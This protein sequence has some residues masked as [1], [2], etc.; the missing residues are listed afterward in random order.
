MSISW[1][2]AVG[3]NNKNETQEFTADPTINSKIKAVVSGLPR[4]ISNL[5]LEF[6][7]DD[8]KDLVANFLDSC[9]KQEN[10]SINTKRAYLIALAYLAR[11][12]K[13]PLELI[14]SSDLK[15]Y[16]DSM[17]RSQTEDPDQSWISTQRTM[18]LPLLKFFKWLAY[19]DLTPQERKQLPRDKYP[20]VL[21]GLVLH[22]K[23]GSKSPIKA[24]DIWGDED[25]GIFLKY[26]TDNP[27]LRFYHALAYETSARPGELLQLKIGDIKIDSDSATG[28]LFAA[29]DIGRY[30]KKRQSRIVGITDFSIQYYQPY[31]LSSHPN[32][33][34]KDA[35]L[36][37]SQEH[38]AFSR[39]LP[40]SGDALRLDYKTFRDKTIPRLLKRPDVPKQDKE[41]LQLLSDKKKWSP[42]TMRHS[43][44][45]KL[46][47]NPNINDYVLRQH[48]GWAK[49]SNM[50]EIYTHELSG[51]SFEDVMLAYGI[52]LKDKKNKEQAELIQKE[53]IGPHCPFCK[54]INVP[55]A[56]FCSSCN[57][58]LSIISYDKIAKEAEQQKRELQEIRTQQ[59]GQAETMRD[60]MRYIQRKIVE[61]A[62]E[63]ARKKGQEW[64][65]DMVTTWEEELYGPYS[66][67]NPPIRRLEELEEEK[68]RQQ[69]P[70]ER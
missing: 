34:S 54:M 35:Y 51:D 42:Y 2:N 22:T 18:A 26:C 7:T 33:G 9:I 48:A 41:H 17:Q 65:G 46:A 59:E 15:T 19:A 45:T 70:S 64:N 24:S 11:E 56:Q 43:S 5:F 38:S 57:K 10:I 12:V 1:E 40:I 47:R 44:I 58:P 6:P 68:R 13:K 14:T 3:I 37:L 60:M 30:G 36:F 32:S 50:V 52:N 31:L 55:D 66:S 69:Q 39:N 67:T 62:K 4:S 20:Q 8:N 29:L 28:K 53:L 16:L 27:R 49:R 23:R 25:V 63:D 21:K 61:E